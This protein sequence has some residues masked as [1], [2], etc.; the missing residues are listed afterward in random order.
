MRWVRFTTTWE[1]SKNRS[2]LTTRPCAGRLQLSKPGNRES[3]EFALLDNKQAEQASEDLDT[4]AKEAPEDSQ[5]LALAAKQALAL[6]R[7]DEAKK[8]ADRAL[9]SDSK[10]FDALLVRARL[11]F[12]SHQP[13]L[14]IADLEKAHQVRPNDLATLQLLLQSQS[15]LGLTRE[16]ALTQERTDRARARITLMDQLSRFISQHPED[17]VPRWSM[18]Q[19]AMEGEMYTLAYQC[20]QAALDLDPNYKPALEALESLRSRKDFDYEATIRSQ[21]QVPGKPPPPGR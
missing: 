20:F 8:L 1:T 14:A 21:M 10:E 4:L 16:A 6:A 12:L 13:K 17:P 18:G 7:A 2:K 11:Q 9:A 5:V 3:A 19:A 15:S